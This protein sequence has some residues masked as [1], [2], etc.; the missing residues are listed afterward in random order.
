MELTTHADYDA[1]PDEVF[2]VISDPD[3]VAA[4]T[5]E[6]SVADHSGAV[7]TR[8]DTT[9]ITT[10]RTLPTDDLPDIARKFVGE[11]LILL[12]EQE[13][14]P[15]GADGSR[16]ADVRLKVE[17]APVSLK[18]TIHLAPK[19]KGATQDLRADLTAKVPLMGGTIEKAAAPA[20]V[21]GIGY[22]VDLVKQRLAR[23]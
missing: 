22:E 13:W 15:A 1:T 6:M 14:G 23:G 16:R 19:G 10:K 21:A 7:T 8:G 4:K 11:V 3:F 17:G 20:I 2:A 5:K 9:V 12:E 18:G